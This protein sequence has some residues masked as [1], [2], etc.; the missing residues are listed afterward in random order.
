MHIWLTRAERVAVW[1][2]NCLL[3]VLLTGLLGVTT[4]QIVLRNVFSVGLP[5]A[6]GLVRL[7]V[8]WLAL[9]GAIAASRDRKHIA[10]N[11]ADRLLPSGFMRPA[12]AVVNGF[13]A[14]V[15]GVVAWY[16]ARF[17]M[18]SREFGDTLLGNWPAWAFQLILPV[19]FAV[20]SYHYLV[21]ALGDLRSSFK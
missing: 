7:A 8:L 10:I 18:D 16:A 17:V 9:A 20:V 2:E 1:L 19:G 14:L 4:A 3:V 13:A 15:S 11:L 5:W 21:R 12:G 6:D